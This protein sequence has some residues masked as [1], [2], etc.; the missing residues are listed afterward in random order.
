MIQSIIIL[1]IIASLG[2][3]YSYSKSS[4]FPTPPDN[5]KPRHLI[6]IKTDQEFLQDMITHHQAAIDICKDY[7][8][9]TTDPNMSYICERIIWQQGYEIFIMKN[10]MNSLD[11]TYDPVKGYRTYIKTVF[12]FYEPQVDNPNVT[13]D[14]IPHFKSNI[15][16]DNQFMEHMI[17]HHQI[18][19]NMCN[20]ILKYTD[21]PYIISFAYDIIREQTR[22]ISLM[23]HTIKS[24]TIFKY[25]SKLLETNETNLP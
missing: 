24:K 4:F 5:E 20:S 13:N 6:D 25:D 8:K 14:D 12:Q 15:L 16:T 11:I 18:G 3:A 17:V 1:S 7:L 21:N 2:L 19:V 23:Q 9:K 22:E 10:T